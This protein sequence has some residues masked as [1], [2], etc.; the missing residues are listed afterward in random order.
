MFQVSPK[1]TAVSFLSLILTISSCILLTVGRSLLK[2]QNA[3][4]VSISLD[5]GLS[6]SVVKAITQDNKGYLWFG[7]EYG[8]NRYDGRK[9]NSYYRQNG[10][11]SDD[12][13]TLTT[14]DAGVVW[15]GTD[16]GVSIWINDVFSVFE[17]TDTLIHAPINDIKFGHDGSV[18]I[19]T[20]GKGVFLYNGDRFERWNVDNGLSSD[21]VRSILFAESG[22]V[23][24]GTKQGVNIFSHS[25]FIYLNENNGLLENRIRKVIEVA[26]NRWWVGSRN[27]INEILWNSK[28]GRIQSITKMDELEGHKVTDCIV[29]SQKRVWVSTENGVFLWNNGTVEWFNTTNGLEASFYYT[30]FED[31]ESTLWLGSLGTGAIQFLGDRFRNI[32]SENGLSNPVVSAVFVDELKNV[33]AG[34]FGGGISIFLKDGS[35]KILNEQNRFLPDDKVYHITKNEINGNTLVATRNGIVE[36]NSS[37]KPV[38][39]SLLSKV[40]PAKYRYILSEKRR[41][42]WLATEDEG[43]IS[44]SP[45]SRHH[46]TVEDGLVSNSTRVLLRHSNGLL[47]IGTTNGISIFDGN[48]FKSL[49]QENGL[50]NQVVLDMIETPNGSVWFTH[51]QGISE[52]TQNGEIRHIPFNYHDE[53]LASYL[54]K[55]YKNKLWVGT[56]KGLVEFDYQSKNPRMKIYTSAMGLVN[57]ELNKGAIYVDK[58]QKF[59]LGTVNGLSRFNPEESNQKEN[60]LTVYFD[61]FYVQGKLTE[62]GGNIQIPFNQNNFSFSFGAITFTDPQTLV[63]EYRLKGIE[64][65]WIATHQTNIRYA[66]ISEGEYQFEVRVIDR[67]GIPSKSISQKIKILPPY[68]RSMWFISLIT[69]V[70]GI[71]IYLTIN[72][73]R[74]SRL[75]ETERIRVRIASDL[76]DDIGASLTEIA[77]QADFIHAITDDDEN[78]QALQELAERSRKIVTTMDDIVWSIDARNDTL[79][80]LTDRI[81]DYANRITSPLDLTVEYEF[82]HLQSD[83]KIHSDSRQ[84]VYLICKEAVNNAVKYAKASKI[85]IRFSMEQDGYC[86]KIS[87]NGI[88]SN[89]SNKKTGHGLKNMMERAKKLHASLQ[90]ENQSGFQIIVKGIHL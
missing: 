32:T 64:T 41:N 33:W 85:L 6:Q 48:V 35:V 49:T 2:A 8:L 11:P 47:Y 34:T 20:E 84:H 73:I 59:W 79:G 62:T 16:S 66:G 28:K 7:T 30:L 67:N 10:L 54:I 29:D 55:E 14:D 89:G 82:N 87:D 57:D 75:V 42:Y 3:P 90:I 17:G 43:I 13:Q 68:W 80:D 52:I 71:V 27:G 12:I 9:M 83:K 77:L 56:N 23:V 24:F 37:F 76:H 36:F 88:G 19:A 45:S 69:F 46:Y 81:Q 53:P 58:N 18:W 4:T 50:L 44:V 51:Y 78:R 63:Y 60:G 1:L 86:L 65:N 26:P 5:A 40:K 38:F 70:I 15:V 39:N 22:E 74:V 72:N 21:S 25:Q 31:V 61:E